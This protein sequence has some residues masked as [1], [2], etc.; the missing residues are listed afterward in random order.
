MKKILFFAAMMTGV[1]WS[2]AQSYTQINNTLNDIYN[3]NHRTIAHDGNNGYVLYSGGYFDVKS[4]NVDGDGILCFDENGVS[5]C[6]LNHNEDYSLEQLIDNEEE[7][8]ALYSYYSKSSG[9]YALCLNTVAKNAQQAKW[10]PDEFFSVNTEKREGRYLYTAVSPDKKKIGVL[11]AGTERKG[12]FEGAVAY[13][14]D[15]TGKQ[16]WSSNVPMDFSGKTFGILD[17]IMNN[18]GELYCALYSYE[19]DSKKDRQ[20]EALHILTVSENNNSMENAPVNFG[21]I[22]NGRLI[23]KKDG[24]LAL[25]GYYLENVKRNESGTYSLIYDLHTGNVN[26]V[27]HKDFPASYKTKEIIKSL[28]N[29]LCSVTIRGLYEFENGSLGLVGEQMGMTSVRNAQTG[30]MDYTLV[31]KNITYNNI[32]ADGNVK[33]LELYKKNQVVKTTGS[34]IRDFRYYGICAYPFFGNNTIYIL[35]NDNAANFSG[36]EGATYSPQ[37]HKKKSILA[38]LSVDAD[39]DASV[40]AISNAAKTKRIV[41]RPIFKTEDGFIVVDFLKKGNGVAKVGVS[42]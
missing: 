14:Y 29:Q 2:F 16:V 9:K 19:G 23:L 34:Y 1:L 20:G 6:Q 32:E 13:V 30:M 33:D 31:A 18:E 35:Y 5:V 4:R 15:N 37:L 3:V 42:F 36:K 41:E 21:H 10:N 26:N 11:L 22:S 8:I 28:P 27:N 40:K 12:G 39:G 38:M 7:V 17:V 25:A 24:S